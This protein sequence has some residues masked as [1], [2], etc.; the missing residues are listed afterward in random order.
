MKLRHLDLF[1]G[2]GGFAIG[3]ESTGGFETVGFVEWEKFP[4]AVLR[5]HWPDVPI[6]GDIK[7]VVGD[8]FGEINI[9]TGG[10]PCQPF[11]AAGK[12]R[13]AADD[14]WLWPEMLRIIN[15]AK[16]DWVLAENVAGIVK[17]ELDTVLADLEAEGYTCGAVI[18]PACAV[19]APHRRDRVWIVAN[20]RNGAWWNG[21]Q[22]SIERNGKGKL[23]TGFGSTQATEAPRPSETPKVVANAKCMYAQREQLC[24]TNPEKRA[25]Q[26]PRQVR[27]CSNG[28]KRG[29]VK[30][31][32]GR[33]AYGLPDWLD[34][35]EPRT[36]TETKD[37]AKRL[38]ALGNAIVPKIAAI[39]GNCILDI[40]NC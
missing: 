21:E 20:S 34:E 25:R 14:R 37:R 29:Q 8:E 18:I 16:P 31:G 30:P 10:F 26:K 6:M 5:K 19:N 23:E 4:Q 39:I 27:P 24:I 32:L 12:R 2:I 28:G 38:K 9:I 3:L 11:S 7:E 36:T 1:S 33:V 35:T 40:E 17:M 15:K 13:G 22:G